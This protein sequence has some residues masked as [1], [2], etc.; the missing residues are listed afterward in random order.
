MDMS[1]LETSLNKALFL[2]SFKMSFMGILELKKK[3]QSVE[4]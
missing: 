2:A 1:F 3:N 4:H